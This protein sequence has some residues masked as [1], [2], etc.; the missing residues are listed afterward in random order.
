MTLSERNHLYQTVGE[1]A[2]FRSVDRHGHV[3]PQRISPQAVFEIVRTYAEKLGVEV[4]LHDLRRSFARLSYLGKVP[5]EQIQLSLGHASLV[6]T[7]V[8]LGVRQDLNNAP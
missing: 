7:E 1:G 2:L 8:Y 5:L 3:K 4:T 6:T